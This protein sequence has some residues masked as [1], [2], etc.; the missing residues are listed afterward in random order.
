[1]I[2]KAINS[3]RLSCGKYVSEFEDMLSEFH[4]VSE[5]VAVS[6]GTDAI[7]VALATLKEFKSKD[8]NE[9]IIPALTFISTANAVIHAGLRPV[10]ADVKRDSYNIDPKNIERQIT[11]KTLAIMPVH[12]FGRPAEMDTI[13]EIASKYNINLLEDASEAHGA[14]FKNK[15]VGTFGDMGAFS[16]YIAHTITSI[17]GGAVI[18]NNEEYAS[19]LRSLRAHGRGCNC[20]SCILNISSDYCSKR[21]KYDNYIDTRFYFER[22]GYSCKMNEIEAA[23]GIEQ[24]ENLEEIVA[25]RRENLNYLTKNLYQY[26]DFLIF[27]NEGKNEKISPMVYPIIVKETAPFKCKDITGY[28]ESHNIE[29]RPLF[30]SIATQ[31]PAYKFMNHKLSDFPNA[32]YLGDNG[33]YIG[34]HQNLTKENLDYIIESFSDFIKICIAKKQKC[35]KTSLILLTLNEIEGS[36]NLFD[37]IIANEFDELIVI[38][39]GSTD[40]T[41]EFFKEKAVKVIPQEKKGRGNAV[42]TA[43][44]EANGENL[45]FFSPDGNEDPGD[46]PKLVEYLEKGYDMVT[47]SRFMHGGRR[48]DVNSLFKYRGFGNRLFT[49]L[50]N[51]IFNGNYTDTINGFRAVKKKCLQ[52]MNIDVGGFLAEFQMSIKALKMNCKVIEIPTWEGRRIGG[53][54]KLNVWTTG[55]IC[56]GLLF[57]E[58]FKKDK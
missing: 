56:L 47:A 58:F 8:K 53:K 12:L 9:V 45:V 26:S 49:L 14:Q 29:T 32:E 43:L 11:D 33:F 38:D 7:T 30:K 3:T 16:F 42:K 2:D 10:F 44:L 46:I 57:K 6:S 25:K 37:K 5:T 31:Q 55:L 54:S 13:C 24:L 48:C 23:V 1:M 20:K 17:E 50:V 51:L 21:F 15:K 28:F 35:K 36:K 27:I 18:T 39:G 52:E 34:I 40:G 22:I 4:G 41:V 19:I